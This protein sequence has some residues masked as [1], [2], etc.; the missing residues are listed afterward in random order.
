MGSSVQL[1]VDTV[2][3][4]DPINR[5]TLKV[6]SGFNGNTLVYAKDPKLDA[7]INFHI[8]IKNLVLD[9]TAIA[10]STSFTLLDWSVSQ[11]T[12]LVNVMFN[13]HTSSQHIGIGRGIRNYDGK[14]SIRGKLIRDQH[15]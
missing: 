6:K 13:M 1:Y 4:G 7:T 15:E 5:P 9:S 12:Q 11:A 3:M 2:L 8:G 14:P 10:P